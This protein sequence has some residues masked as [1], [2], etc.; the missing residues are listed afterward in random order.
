MTSDA[1]GLRLSLFPGRKS[2]LPPGFR[3]S[4]GMTEGVHKCIVESGRQRRGTRRG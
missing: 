4:L 1:T 3:E 2:I